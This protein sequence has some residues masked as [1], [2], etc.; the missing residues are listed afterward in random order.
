[1]EEAGSEKLE[2][3]KKGL[4][5]WR[6]SKNG[7]RG[8][9]IPQ[10]LRIQAVELLN[11]YSAWHLQKK[12]GINTNKIKS[13]EKEYSSSTVFIALPSEPKKKEMISQVNFALKVNR[14]DW[15]LEGNLSLKDWQSALR[16]LEVVK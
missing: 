9:E 6:K 12:L 1:M 16:L 3:L 14:G 11:Y 15:S 13:W 4:S 8:R 10:E 7:R 5:E 2:E